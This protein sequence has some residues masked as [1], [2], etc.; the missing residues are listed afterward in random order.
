MSNITLFNSSNVPAFARNNELSETAKALT[1]GGSNT[2]RISIKGGVFRLIAGGKEIASVEDRHLDVV[3]V[4]AAPKVSRIFY[5]GSY[6]ADKI[7]RPD[8]W[9]SDG[10]KPDTGVKEPQNNTCMGC[11]Q[12]E[13]GSGQGNTRACRFQ[14]RLAV[15]LANNMEGDVLQL[16]LP[17]TSVFG[18]E[19]GDKRPLQAYAR[20]L[21]AQTPPVN[22]EQIVTRMKFDTKAESPKLFFQPVRWLTDEEYPTVVAQGETAEAKAAVTMTVAQTDGVK[23][24]PMTIPGSAPKS[25]TK[26]VVDTADEDD[27]EEAPAPKAAKAPKTKPVADVDD[28][29][30]VRKEPAKATAVPAKKSKLAD[31]VSDWDDE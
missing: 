16:T 19:D 26:P 21:A 7:V 24:A 20:F 31:I 25:A 29:P 30:E 14:Q 6:D 13:A 12:N 22:P 10:E 9:S 18:K 2:K 4:R 8:C 11:P 5:A 27:A 23:A 1:G 3:V 15:V 17:A 28:E